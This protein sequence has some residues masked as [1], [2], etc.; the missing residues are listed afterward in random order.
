M[1]F[2]ANC[3]LIFMKCLIL[4]SEKNKKNSTSLSSAEFAQRVVKVKQSDYSPY[5]N[6]VL[7][8]VINGAY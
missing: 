7:M 5:Y 3:H 4:F 6:K 1:T 8:E 2:H